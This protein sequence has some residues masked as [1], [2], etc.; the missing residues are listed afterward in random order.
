MQI[1]IKVAEQILTT[2]KKDIFPVVIVSAPGRMGE[3]YSTDTL[4]SLTKEI[5]SCH[6]PVEEDLLLSCGETISA[7]L[8]VYTLREKGIKAK[9]LTGAQAGIITDGNHNNSRII[10]VDTG[11]IKELIDD[12]IIP[13]ITGFQGISVEGEI[14]TLGRGGSD[15]SAAVIAAALEV[16]SLEIFSDVDSIMTADPKIV[17]DP[18]VISKMN[19]QDI[20][21]LTIQGAKVIHPRAAEVARK[22]GIPIKIRSTFTGKNKTTI[23]SVKTDKPIIGIVNRDKIGYAKIASQD[24]ISYE[25]SLKVFEYLSEKGISVDFIDIRPEAITFVVDMD[26]MDRA[27]NILL[28]KKID[29][30]FSTDFSMI[31]IVGAGMTGI[32]G[33]MSK[34]VA[35]L[36]EKRI[37]IYQ[38][39]DSHSS[40]SIMIS[41]EQEV[42]AVNAL[43]KAFDL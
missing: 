33:I 9:A 17:R 27:S 8:L 38:T 11:T 31:S 36:Q 13:V 24:S 32:P 35:T 2:L 10:Q 5:T 14:T 15:T 3:P 16:D 1:R 20:F 22:A 30:S 43:H 6:L 23:H 4:L 29:C 40:I 39:T 7:C 19:Y 34:I 12:N 25:R 26:Q 37:S 28:N 21:E 41:K 18:K 42:N